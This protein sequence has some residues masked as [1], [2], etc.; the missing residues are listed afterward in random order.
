MSALQKLAQI[1][2]DYN[3]D[4]CLDFAQVQESMGNI[5][6]ITANISQAKNHFKKAMKIYEDVWA[7]EPELI[8]EKYQEIQELYPQ[9]GISLARA[10]LGAWIHQ[11]HTPFL[12]IVIILS[13]SFQQCF[14]NSSFQTDT[15][16]SHTQSQPKLES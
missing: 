12:H 2:K 4:H 1:I 3:S 16:V 13:E 8:E 10:I 9:I 7:D 11:I 15:L 6:L 5:C 14:P